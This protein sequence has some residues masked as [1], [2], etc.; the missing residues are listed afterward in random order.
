[1][2]MIPTLID[3][4]SCLPGSERGVRRSERVDLD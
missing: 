1:M 4:D 2:I 3:I